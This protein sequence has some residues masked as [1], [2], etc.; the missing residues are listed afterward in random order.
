MDFIFHNRIN[1]FIEL[2]RIKLSPLPDMALVSVAPKEIPLSCRSKAA[3]VF[4]KN[5]GFHFEESKQWRIPV[6]SWRPFMLRTSGPTFTI[7]NS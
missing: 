1:H 6:V 4:Q 2:L 5:N 7:T 3:D